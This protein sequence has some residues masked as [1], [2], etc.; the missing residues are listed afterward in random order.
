MGFQNNFLIIGH[1]GAAGLAPENTLASFQRAFNLGVDA[2]E[3]DVHL[4]ESQLVVIHDDKVDR[5]TNGLGLVADFSLENLQKLNAGEGQT[6]PLLNEVFEI[7]PS[8]TG[9]NIELK[10]SETGTALSKQLPF[11]HGPAVENLLVSSFN[12]AELAAFHVSKPEVHCAPIFSKS[13]NNI[14][15][16][17]R[18]LDA[19]SVNISNQIANTLLI[20]ELRDN[21]FRVLVYTINDVTRSRELANLGASGVFTD[22]PD[23]V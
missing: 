2:V 13:Q 15:D 4:V 5:T 18:E 3:L 17:A 14:V 11:L 9:I 20:K 6:I 21:G 10:G 12:H 7:L 22:F 8:S 23:R 16:I 19:W 1:R